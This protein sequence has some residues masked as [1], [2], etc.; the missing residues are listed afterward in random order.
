MSAPT[1]GARRPQDFDVFAGGASSPHRAA[2]LDGRRAT[3]RS[4]TRHDAVDLSSCGLGRGPRHPTARTSRGTATK[5]AFAARTTANDPLA[6]YTMNAD[7]TACAQAARTSTT[8]RRWPTACS[9]HNFDPAF[10]PPG[11]DGVKRIVFASTRGQPRLDRHSFDY[12]GPQRTPAD[13]TKPNANLYVLEPD[14]TTAGKS[15]PPAHVPAQHGA[16]ARASCRTAASSSRRRSARRASTSSRSAG[17]TS[18][19]ATTTRST[20]SAARSAITQATYVVELADKNFA[21]DLQQPSALHGAGALGVFNRSIGVD[22]TSTNAERLPGRS[23]RH[24][25]RTRRRRSSRLLSCTRSTVRAAIRR[26]VHE[27]AP[28]PTERC[29]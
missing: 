2:S 20:P 27:P 16:L 13:P 26:L 24:Q 14:P 9:M 1:A 15:G 28:L 25:Y 29:S 11:P 23:E 12:T 4:A 3:S 5:I 10:S 19:A 7:G 21:D 8:T 22:F 18:T 6:I 17:R